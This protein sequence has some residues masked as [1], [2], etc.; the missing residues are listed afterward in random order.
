MESIVYIVLRRMR[1]PLLVLL[2]AYS[3]SIL[4]LTLVPGVDDQGQPWRMDFFEATYFASYMATTIGFGEIPYVFSPAQRMWVTLCIYLTVIAWLYGI[5]AILALI[6]D[7][8]FRHAVEESRF[9]R[10]VRHI[11]ERFYIVC[12]YGDTGRA[13]V[14]AL[15]ERYMRAVVVDSEPEAISTLALKD[16]PVMVPGLC[17]NATIP[18]KLLRA[19]L[20]NP[21]CAGVVAVTHEDFAN[22]KIA[23]TSKLLNPPLPVI[24][25]AETPDHVANIASFGTDY[26][27]NPFDLFASQLAMAIRAPSQFLLYEWLTEVPH[28]RM[29]EPLFPPCGKWIL[30]GF[31]RFG[32][33]MYSHLL[34]QGIHVTI[35]E[36]D[37]DLTRPPN[38][39][40]EGRGTEADTLRQAGIE[41]AVGIVAGTD[42]DAN[43]LSI[44]MTARELNPDLFVVIRQNRSANKRLFQ[45]FHAELTMHASALIAREVRV[46][47]TLPLLGE[48]LRRAAARDNRWANATASRIIAVMGDRVPDVWTVTLSP[49]ESRGACE[50]FKGGG[51]VRL[52]HLG[53]DPRNRHRRLACIPLL[54]QRE[55]E[56]LLM[57][58]GD[59]ELRRGDEILFCGAY[60]IAG[61][62][63]WL[64][65]NAMALNYVVNGVEGPDGAVW[66]AWR[67]WRQRRAGGGATGLENDS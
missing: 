25:R 37:F 41:D 61:R 18:P 14:R 52:R 44:V 63:R 15:T 30:C 59:T 20:R 46:L 43:N 42:V 19:G 28:R 48:F 27:V 47:L 55:E 40:I 53:L 21:Y 65:K 13:L 33:A 16:Y 29:P 1:V 36:A 2:A 7:P 34:E 57:P 38:G 60:G 50:C 54:L 64:I 32:K 26:I 6:Q 45:A 8:A 62:M 58:D 11:R 10:S 35:I 51:E 3:I 12:G 5:G 31:G 67:R 39:T 22:L 9:A 17:A 24:C 4:G 23:I 49:V 66:R 56:Y